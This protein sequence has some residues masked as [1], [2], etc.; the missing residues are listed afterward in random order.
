LYRDNGDRRQDLTAE[1]V[2]DIIWP[3]PSEQLKLTHEVI[4]KFF[5]SRDFWVM[6]RACEGAI[7]GL[8][9]SP[10]RAMRKHNRTEDY[11][12]RFCLRNEPFS[13]SPQRV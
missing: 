10:M 1:Q 11:G 5:L 8:E 3:L 13:L 7:A 6:G 12:R 2:F 9:D 4:C